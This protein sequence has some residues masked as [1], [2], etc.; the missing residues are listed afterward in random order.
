MEMYSITGKGATNTMTED[1]TPF[2]QRLSLTLLSLAIAAAAIVLGKE[3]LLPILFAILLA[4][5]LLPITNYL[6]RKQLPRVLSIAIPVLLTLI[7][8]GGL[9]YFLSN[10][11]INFLDDAPELKKKLTEVGVSFQKLSLIH[12]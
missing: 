10:Q 9:V 3:V 1:H 6:Q 5:L 12:I 11:I 8:V 7:V 2:Y 4:M